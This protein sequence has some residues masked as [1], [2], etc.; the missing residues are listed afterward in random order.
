MRRSQ[1]VRVVD[2]DGAVDVATSDYATCA[3]R[4]DGTVWCWGI[5]GEV[6][7][8][9]TEMVSEFVRPRPI[10]GISDAVD[11]S[12]Q[13]MGF[14]VRLASG[15][16]RCWGAVTS[17]WGIAAP[18]RTVVTV[19]GV[20]DAEQMALTM[21]RGCVATATGR[22]QCWGANGPGAIDPMAMRG[23]RYTSAREISGLSGVRFVA[24]NVNHTCAVLAT[25]DILCLGQNDVGQLGT[26]SAARPARVLWR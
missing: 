11:V 25:G 19:P 18:Y 22:A 24:T 1:P 23:D 20:T 3:V 15:S 6:P 21:S 8:G 14:C 4:T 9:S 17:S 2:L 10:V 12:A 26:T 5:V 16:V 7:D 13:P